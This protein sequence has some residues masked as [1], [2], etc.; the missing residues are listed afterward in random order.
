MSGSNSSASGGF[1][2][3]TNTALT[4]EALHDA[5]QETLAGISGIDGTLVRPRWQPGFPPGQG[6]NQPAP[7]V[8]WIA[9]GITGRDAADYPAMRHHNGGPSTLTRWSIF[10]VLV[11][12]YG[13]DAD[14][15]A[16]RLRDGLYVNQNWEALSAVGVKLLE[17]QS[18]TAVPDLVNT[19]YIDHCDL[20]LRF[21]QAV[22]RDYNILDIASS[23]GVISSDT[24]S[25][26]PF[27]VNP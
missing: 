11:S 25:S 10:T 8:Q 15:I 26:T 3:Q 12:C 24:G 14:G 27:N 9:F 19:G 4:N 2:T 1:L 13:P 20:P 17:A 6:P 23:D 5:I 16:E 18:A 21:A 7:D 22:D